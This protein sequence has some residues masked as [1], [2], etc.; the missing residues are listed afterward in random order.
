[1]NKGV[2]FQ[3][4]KYHYKKYL[5]II[6]SC[7]G[8]ALLVGAIVYTLMPGE[9]GTT[10]FSPLTIINF[11]ILLTSFILILVGNVQGTTIAYSGILTFVFYLMVDFGS[12]AFTS[13]LT[14]TANLFTGDP[15]VII[16]SVL[17]L[18]GGIAA[19]VIGILL[20]IRLRQYLTG[21]YSSYVG[22]RNLALVFTIVA[23][24]FNGVVPAILLIY[25][26]PLKVALALLENFAVIF[27]AIAAFFTICR[28][29]SEY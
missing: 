13:L 5:A 2:F 17:L 19:F 9:D 11:L 24:L 10:Y 28:L 16:L 15:L 22:L 29:K 23:I 20:Y 21:R 6:F 14:G 7:I 3:R 18:G 26:M 12:F 1:M 27:E 8:L 4:I 25:E